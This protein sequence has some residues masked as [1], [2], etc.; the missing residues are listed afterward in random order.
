MVE[1]DKYQIVCIHSAGTISL[2][3]AGFLLTQIRPRQASSFRASL[4]GSAS[5]NW[6]KNHGRY[7]ILRYLYFSLKNSNFSSGYS[8][9]MLGA[10]TV[11][12][13]RDLLCLICRYPTVQRQFRAFMRCFILSTLTAHAAMSSM[14]EKP[15]AQP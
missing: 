12:R 6:N 1:A 8:S 4:S 13:Q 11:P 3:R 5:Q 9:P 15:P 2:P 10:H 14:T 7:S